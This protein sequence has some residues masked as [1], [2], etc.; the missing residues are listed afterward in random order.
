MVKFRVSYIKSDKTEEKTDQT[1]Q[2]IKSQPI[3]MTTEAA[4]VC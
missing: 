4:D 1:K 3:G 2:V